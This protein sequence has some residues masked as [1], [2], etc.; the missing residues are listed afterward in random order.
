MKEE[1]SAYFQVENEAVSRLHQGENI[2]DNSLYLLITPWF[3][4]L[5]ENY[6]PGVTLIQV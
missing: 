2:D 4:Y 3:R 1:K 5:R 6:R